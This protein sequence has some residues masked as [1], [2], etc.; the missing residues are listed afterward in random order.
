MVFVILTVLSA[1]AAIYFLTERNKS[2][3]AAVRSKDELAEYVDVGYFQ[4]DAGS[5]LKSAAEG[6]NK[7][8]VEFL[9]SK[10][11]EI[12]TVVTGDSSGDAETLRSALGLKPE[13]NAKQALER[14]RRSLGDAQAA[15]TA[16][17]QL[18]A[19]ANAQLATALEES[20][21]T[22]K[23]AD[24]KIRQLSETLA[25]YRESS[26]RALAAIG[27]LKQELV[28]ARDIAKS[29]YANQLAEE[30]DKQASLVAAN[31]GLAARVGELQKQV[32]QFR[33][34]PSD[35]S[36]LVDGT[37]VDLSTV[38]DQVYVSLGSKDRVRPGMTFEVYPDSSAILYDPVTDRQTP[39]LASIELIKIGDT[40]ST[41]RVTRKKQGKSISRG[42][43]LAN[44]VYSP[45]YQYKFMVHG[46]FDVDA[47]G[48]VTDGE[49]DYI[50]AKIRDWGGVVVESEELGPDIDFVVVG[51]VPPRVQL[52]SSLGEDEAA[53]ASSLAASRAYDSYE[54]LITSARAAQIPVLN[55][56]R[57]QILT[58]AA[59][60]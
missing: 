7:N 4:Q 20:E 19:Q 5:A 30:K 26:E 8:V 22:S 16:Q 2:D 33:I 50:R 11:G 43:V 56:N 31:Q 27:E 23:A 25:P 35:P 36:L 57:F 59:E 14:A 60:R 58:G 39:G 54:A 15:V 44:A 38:K 37:I 12:L 18:V 10:Q 29:E 52:R 55:W 42:D 40:T 28:E 32:D 6:E 1:S 3:A 51:S 13:E 45:T 41:A 49:A 17:E 53:Y 9:V 34:R 21:A 48:K 24:E 47:D 46:K